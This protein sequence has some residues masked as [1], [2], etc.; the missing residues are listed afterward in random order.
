M[1]QKYENIGVMFYTL[2]KLFVAILKFA[3]VYTELK[4]IIFFVMVS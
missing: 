1:D 4:I 3:L 2:M